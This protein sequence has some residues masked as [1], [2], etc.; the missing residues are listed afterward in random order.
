MVFILIC[1]FVA[2]DDLSW[3]LMRIVARFCSSSQSQPCGPSSS[4]IAILITRRPGDEVSSHVQVIDK[5]KFTRLP[6]IVTGT[7][8][9]DA[10]THPSI[11]PIGTSHYRVPGVFPFQTFQFVYHQKTGKWEDSA[12]NIIKEWITIAGKIPKILRAA[13]NL[14]SRLNIHIANDVDE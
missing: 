9:A 13:P 10:Q 11:V 5:W 12:E 1:G 7:G 6:A 3:I 2:V 8:R 4:S 14:D